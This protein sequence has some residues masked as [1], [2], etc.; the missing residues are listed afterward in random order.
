M[1]ITFRWKLLGSYLLLILVLGGGLYLYLEQ[2]LNSF[3]EAV[4]QG[5]LLT[6]AKLAVLVAENGVRDLSRD[7]PGIAASLGQ[8]GSARVTSST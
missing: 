7:A 2:R 3:Q 8:A 1:T 5:E 4:V 6:E